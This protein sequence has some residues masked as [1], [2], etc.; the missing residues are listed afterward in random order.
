MST[1]RFVSPERRW[2]AGLLVVLACWFGW[3]VSV[4]VGVLPGGL[5]A[6]GLLAFAVPVTRNCLIVTDEGLT[7]RRAV[8]SI[9]VPW[10]R[11]AGFRVGRP[12]WLWGGF[13]VIAVCRDG[14]E[15]A[16]LST[17]AYFWV[18]SPHHLDELHRFCW[19]LEEHLAACGGF[20][21]GP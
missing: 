21:P 14:S 8:R 6:A 10:E 15:A 19:T 5:A 3:R 18:P 1:L 9:R 17:R 13:C 16:L 12:G 20:A 4:A 11:I 2:R 7:D